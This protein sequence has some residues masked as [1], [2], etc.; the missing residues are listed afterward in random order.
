MDITLMA[1]NPAL[2]RGHFSTRNTS[3]PLYDEL[4]ETHEVSRFQ[5]SGTYIYGE[6]IS[7]TADLEPEC[8]LTS[9]RDTLVLDFLRKVPAQIVIARSLIT[10]E[11]EESI[12]DLLLP[13]LPL[14]SRTVKG[15]IR[16]I[17]KGEPSFSTITILSAD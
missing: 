11:E 10:H 3:L 15:R 9:S 5:I 2:T 7:C 13:R 17:G 8:D 12:E 6:L 1:N 4:E 16:V 14:R